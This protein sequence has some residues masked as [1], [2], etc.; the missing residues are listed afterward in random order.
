MKK[1]IFL[2][3]V[4]NLMLN[5]QKNEGS[6]GIK[7]GLNLATITGDASDNLSTRLA[8]HFGFM[9][10]SK[11]SERMALQPELLFSS[12]GAIEKTGN[13]DLQYRLNY[14]NVP[15]LFKFYVS[16]EFSFD[17][18]P[19]LGVLVSAKSS[20]RSSHDNDI[21]VNFSDTD[22]GLALGVGYKFINKVNLSARYNFGLKNI[23]NKNYDFLNDGTIKNSVFQLSLGYYFNNY[24]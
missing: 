11:I 19:Q 23:S 6:I 21:K 10:E 15:I 7:G 8:F 5:A 12:Q 2:F 18:G 22:Y 24:K 3:L 17:V 1:I 4:S 20:F 14:I 16:D 13:E 9:L